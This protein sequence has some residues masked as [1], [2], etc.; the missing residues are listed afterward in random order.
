MNHRAMVRLLVV[1]VATSVVA[2][3]SDHASNLGTSVAEPAS[4]VAPARASA[5]PSPA[6]TPSAAPSASPI[7]TPTPTR[8]VEASAAPVA[9][10]PLI[11]DWTRRSVAGLD[12]LS[13]TRATASVGTTTV[14]LGRGPYDTDVQQRSMIW[15]S[16][17]GRHWERTLRTSTDQRINAITAGGPGFVAVGANGT[18]AAVWTSKDGATWRP[19][20]DSAFDRGWMQSIVAT[21]SGLVVFGGRSDT[22]SRVIWTS[23]DGIEWLAATNESGLRVARGVEAVAA[24]EGQALA[25]V[26]PGDTLGRVEVWATTGRAEWEQVATLPGDDRFTVYRAAGGP[27]G[28]VAFGATDSATPYVAWYS[29]DGRHWEKAKTGP[30]VYT[31]I[32]GV[33]AGFIATGAVGSLGGETC[34][35]QRD[36]HGHTWTSAD[37]RTWQRMA[38]SKDFEWASVSE[39]MVVGRNLV[40]IGGSYP[41]SGHFYD[42]FVP[43]RWTAPLPRISI[44]DDASDRPSKPQTC[45]G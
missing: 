13:D 3:C 40:G 7:E 25:F 44:A 22:D 24:W 31:S 2:A 12:G 27:L 1:A 15:R 41:G 21:K 39:L 45:G 6:A 38:V 36:Y 28:W 17:D 37:G 43:T 9:A 10:K 5:F 14:L 11:V 20:V 30:D 29:E 4:S 42:A 33:D 16:T 32:I 18:Q 19:V 35:D 34:G 26:G 23:P 8:T